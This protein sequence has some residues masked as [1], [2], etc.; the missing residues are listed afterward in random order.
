MKFTERLKCDF[1]KYCYLY[2]VKLMVYDVH[3]IVGKCSIK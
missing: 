2:Y 3:W 1:V